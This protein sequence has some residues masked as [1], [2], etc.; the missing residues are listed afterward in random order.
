MRGEPGNEAITYAASQLDYSHMHKRTCQLSSWLNT[1]DS[2]MV[3]KI[4][5]PLKVPKASSSYKQYPH[6]QTLRHGQLRV[7]I[8]LTLSIPLKD[9]V[10]Q[11]DRVVSCWKLSTQHTIH[12]QSAIELAEPREGRH[13]EP[14]DETLI[15]QP[16]WSGIDPCKVCKVSQP[17][18]RHYGA[19]AIVLSEV[20]TSP[21]VLKSNV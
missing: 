18:W 19:C 13:T 2:F 20:V 17:K 1:Q 9:T 6:S 5:Q 12:P 21:W 7:W 16:C 8:N 10:C 14:H 11:S 3:G 4:H 15:V